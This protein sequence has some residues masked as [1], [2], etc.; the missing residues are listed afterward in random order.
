MESSPSSCL[1]DD[2]VVAVAAAAATP[3]P[4]ASPSPASPPTLGRMLRR[5]SRILAAARS[6][7]AG[8]ALGVPLPSLSTSQQ[9]DALEEAPGLGLDSVLVPA[10]SDVA[11]PGDAG[12]SGLRTASHGLEILGLPLVCLLYTSPSPRDRG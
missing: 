12:K 1:G 4:L 6:E 10:L 3:P 8:I 5:A 11:L 2:D 9:E 7:M